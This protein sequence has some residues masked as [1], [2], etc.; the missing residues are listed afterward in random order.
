MAADRR[1]VELSFRLYPVA[2][3]PLAAVQ[4]DLY[5]LILDTLCLE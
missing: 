2:N 1:I 3:E 5:A 4:R